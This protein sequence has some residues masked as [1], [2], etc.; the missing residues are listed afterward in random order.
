MG[1]P[2]VGTLMARMKISDPEV[3]RKRVFANLVA[4][5]ERV[6]VA[7]LQND[8]DAMSLPGAARQTFE[9][10]HAMTTLRGFRPD[11][12]IGDELAEIRTKTLVLWGERDTFVPCG[13]GREVMAA[14]PH[15][16]FEAVPDAGHCIH[17]ELPE[18]IAQRITSTA[19]GE[20]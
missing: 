1:T 10:M 13:I 5:P 3:N 17:V 11:V 6:P 4:H 12:L 18:L 19:K 9:L 20:L 14:L 8:I 7:V 16:T 2:L 15:S